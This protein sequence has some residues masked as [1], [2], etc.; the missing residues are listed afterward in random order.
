[1]SL[2]CRLQ[3]IYVF[4][5]RTIDRYE[6]FVDSCQFEMGTFPSPKALFQALVNKLIGT[7]IKLDVDTPRSAYC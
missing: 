4:M 5:V 2:L 7:T 1:M 3:N 6:C